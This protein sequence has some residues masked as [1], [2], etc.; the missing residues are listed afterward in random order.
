MTCEFRVHNLLNSLIKWSI[1]N[2]IMHAVLKQ[3]LTRKIP[4]ESSKLIWENVVVKDTE[5]LDSKK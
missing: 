1:I 5:A 2:T 3:N 4:L